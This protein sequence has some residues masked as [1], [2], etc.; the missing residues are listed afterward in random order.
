MAA[1]YKY[2]HSV[3]NSYLADSLEQSGI[4][5]K[6]VTVTRNN[7]PVVYGTIIG[8]EMVP[9]FTGAGVSNNNYIVFSVGRDDN[10]HSDFQKYETVVYNVYTKGKTPGLDIV[11]AITDALG[12]RDFTTYDLEEYQIEQR[13][14]ESYHFF[15]IE[16]NVIGSAG[17]MNNGKEA[18]YYMG[19]VMV[20]YSYTY[21]MDNR[22]RKLIV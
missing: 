12:R 18:G 7:R 3:I 1:N 14:Q 9:E 16:Y 11:N 2:P 21:D 22:G 15:D 6:T 5:P 17:A 20:R 19:T 10:E 13:G 8:E 4:L